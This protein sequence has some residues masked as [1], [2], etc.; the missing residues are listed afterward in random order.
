MNPGQI[1]VLPADAP[2]PAPVPY[3]ENGYLSTDHCGAEI[4]RGD[5]EAEAWTA[6]MPT[7]DAVGY[8]CTL[9]EHGD[10]PHACHIRRDSKPLV[11]LVWGGE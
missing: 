11:V 5:M 2:V 6:T 3:G 8:Y 1:R 10:S 4:H 7:P 9:P